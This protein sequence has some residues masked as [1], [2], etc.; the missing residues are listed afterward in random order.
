VINTSGKN[1]LKRKD[2][3][4][5]AST[6]PSIIEENDDGN[7]GRESSSWCWDHGIVLYTDFLSMSFS[8]Y[9]LI[10]LRTIKP[11]EVLSY[12]ELYPPSMYD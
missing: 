4:P 11:K 12:N 2:Y 6:S 5:Y 8:F 7:S 10:E 9:F 1:Q 3:L